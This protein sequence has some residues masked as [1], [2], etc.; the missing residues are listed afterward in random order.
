MSSPSN[1]I[2][3]GHSLTCPLPDG[4]ISSA[5]YNRI[6]GGKSDKLV[7]LAHCSIIVVKARQECRQQL[8]VKASATRRISVLSQKLPFLRPI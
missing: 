7:R 1:K 8:L 2:S 6:I 4:P 5:R 3:N